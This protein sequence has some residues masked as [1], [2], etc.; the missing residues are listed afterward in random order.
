MG[1]AIFPRGLCWDPIRTQVCAPEA[2]CVQSVRQHWQRTVT[3][4]FPILFGLDHRDQFVGN[5]FGE[6]LRIPGTLQHGAG[7][8]DVRPPQKVAV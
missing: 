8:V 2:A 6:V 3:I 1:Y 7:M 5:R 4:R